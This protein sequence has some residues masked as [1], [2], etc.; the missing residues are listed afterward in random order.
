MSLDIPNQLFEK[1]KQQLPTDLDKQVFSTWLNDASEEEIDEVIALYGDYFQQI[2]D[3][4]PASNDLHNL[5][6]SRL[7]TFDQTFLKKKITIKIWPLVSKIAAVAAILFLTIFLYNKISSSKPADNYNA[8]N[9]VIKKLQ[10]ILPGSDKALLTLSDGTTITLDSAKNGQLA[11]QGKVKIY[12]SS[13]GKIMYDATESNG[14]L[15]NTFVSNTISTP[16]GGQ[17]QLV[18][19]D[20]TKV[21]LNAASSIKFPTNFYGNERSIEL[22]GEAYFEVAK[23]KAHPFIVNV[24]NMQVQVLGT[25]FNIMAYK[26]EISTKTTL[27]EGSVKIIKDKKQQLIIPGEQASVAEGIK[28][29][30]V[31][32]AEVMEWKNG[33]FNFSHENLEGIMRKISR[34]YDVKIEYHGKMT[35]ED[36]VGT[37]PRSQNIIDVLNYLQLTGLVH[38]QVIERRVIVMP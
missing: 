9:K 21:W 22:T 3:T 20:G 16:R 33:N 28:I 1:L 23:D 4:E 13:Q 37:I 35:S 15:Q 36:F 12:K 25:H 6:E 18:L 32:V 27:L 17:Y 30:K 31:N 7:D 14:Q 11:H 10:P 5:I 24:N 26:D 38:F 2:L 8:Q 29:L 34:W 19:P